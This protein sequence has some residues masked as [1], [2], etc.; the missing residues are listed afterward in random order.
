MTGRRNPP[1]RPPTPD[2]TLVTHPV[3]HK[4]EFPTRSF[5]PGVAIDPSTID[6][7]ISAR[8]EWWATFHRT[9]GSISTRGNSNDIQEE[10]HALLS[11]IRSAEAVSWR[12]DEVVFPRPIWGFY[13]FLTDYDQATKESVPLAM[14]NWVQLIQQ[15]QGANNASSPDPYAN[16]VSRRLRMDLVEIEQEVSASTSV[17][18]VRECLRAHVRSLEITDEEGEE[19]DSWPPPTRNMVGLVLNADLVQKL[20]SLYFDQED[21]NIYE[22]YRV[23]AVDITWQPSDVVH[24]GYKG[25]KDI[26][27]TDLA[28]L[29]QLCMGGL[30]D[31]Y[32]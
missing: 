27:I 23:Q 11:E 19:E 31:F 32:Y 20:A 1:P 16:E 15:V 22:A 25:V 9:A 12:R 29:Y 24:R 3:P 14:Q 26:P 10:N 28:R 30:E 18:R 13:V 7:T 5:G 8:E 17:D 4:K 2:S 6:P 21:L